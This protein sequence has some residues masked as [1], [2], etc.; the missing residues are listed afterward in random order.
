MDRPEGLDCN[1][2]CHGDDPVPAT[3]KDP[4]T[5]NAICWDCLTFAV[6]EGGETICSRDPAYKVGVDGW[7][8]VFSPRHSWWGGRG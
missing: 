4:A 7:E 1:C 2:G 3:T 8:Y 5:D 6:N